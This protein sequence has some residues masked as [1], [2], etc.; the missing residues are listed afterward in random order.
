MAVGA[1]RRDRLFA[2]FP[3]AFQAILKTEGVDAVL[4][5]VKS[6]NANAHLERFHGSLKFDSL[7]EVRKQRRLE[8][9]IT[10]RLATGD[11]SACRD[12]ESVD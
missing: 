11:G 5:P 4:P 6:S 10:P 8:G 3:P 7:K 12:R 2:R 9:P 1:E